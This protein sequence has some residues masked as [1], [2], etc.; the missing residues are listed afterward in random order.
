MA[1]VSMVDPSWEVAGKVGS[2][3][4]PDA[5]GQA[6]NGRP[7]R[8]IRV[9][10]DRPNRWLD[11]GEIQEGARTERLRDRAVVPNLVV[12]SPFHVVDVDP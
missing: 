7:T 3:V 12:R 8:N 5:P 10:G 1:V 6:A 9:S 11:R 2:H 4:R